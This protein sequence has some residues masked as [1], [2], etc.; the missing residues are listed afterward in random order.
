[1]TFN[2]QVHTLCVRDVLSDERMV[3]QRIELIPDF[4]LVVKLPDFGR[5]K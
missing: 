4:R 3:D 2:V 5:S 1:M